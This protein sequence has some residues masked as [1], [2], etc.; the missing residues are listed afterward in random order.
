[1]NLLFCYESRDAQRFLENAAAQGFLDVFRAGLQTPVTRHRF[2][3]KNTITKAV[4]SVWV[5]KEFKVLQV[6]ADARRTR[7][8]YVNMAC[9]A[10]RLRKYQLLR[11]IHTQFG[12]P[13]DV[14][15]F[16]VL[17]TR[18]VEWHAQNQDIP[19]GTLQVPIDEVSDG[20]FSDGGE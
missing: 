4:A 19:D 8:D 15:A 20:D 11:I 17:V 13:F 6:I 10:L 2:D 9:E 16:G 18:A 1:M 12:Y 14:D 7:D 3:A 5:E